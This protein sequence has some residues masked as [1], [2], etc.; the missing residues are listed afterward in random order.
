MENQKNQDLPTLEQALNAAV[1]EAD[2]LDIL[3]KIAE[4][5]KAGDLKSAAF[6]LDRMPKKQEKTSNTPLQTL[7]VEGYEKANAKI[8]LKDL[9]DNYNQ[10]LETIEQ[11]VRVVSPRELANEL[12]ELGYT[13]TNGAGNKVY[14]HGLT[15]K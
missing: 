6:L 5:A 7:L 13:V 4:Q 1:S 15:K 11:H 9:A 14:V 10:Y 12:R 3:K 2:I 8:L